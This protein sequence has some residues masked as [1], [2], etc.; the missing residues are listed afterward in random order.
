MQSVHDSSSF[1]AFGFEA[2]IS[3]ILGCEIQDV[4]HDVY[5]GKGQFNRYNFFVT[6]YNHDINRQGNIYMKNIPA[7]RIMLNPGCCI[8]IASLILCII[9]LTNILMF[10]LGLIR[11]IC[12]SIASSRVTLN[13]RTMPNP[14]DNMIKIPNCKYLSGRVNNYYNFTPFEFSQKLFSIG[15]Q[16]ERVN[17]LMAKYQGKLQRGQTVQIMCYVEEFEKYYTLVLSNMLIRHLYTFIVLFLSFASISFIAVYELS[18]YL[19]E[20]NILD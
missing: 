10:I 19:F 14:F 16:T 20:F 11:F 17:F 7:L 2:S 6:T 8:T 9:P 13:Y 12:I 15:L 5:V 1:R 4:G 18:Y 3:E